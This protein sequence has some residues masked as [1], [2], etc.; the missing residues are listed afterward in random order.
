MS[1]WKQVREPSA[2]RVVRRT[3]RF[4]LVYEEKISLDRCNPPKAGEA[5]TERKSQPGPL[6]RVFEN[7]SR[8]FENKDLRV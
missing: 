5:E 4:W 6:G 1:V 2:R 7:K 3:G 8:V